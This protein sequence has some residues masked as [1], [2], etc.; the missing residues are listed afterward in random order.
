MKRPPPEVKQT[1]LGSAGVPPAG[2]IVCDEQYQKLAGGD[3]SAPRTLRRRRCLRQQPGNDDQ[4]RHDH[5]R[6]DAPENHA[7]LAGDFMLAPRR[8]PQLLLGAER[9]RG[10]VR[11][12]QLPGDQAES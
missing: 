2:F 3:A 1:S 9:G 5:Q 8:F 11:R 12:Q 6:E 10:F 4:Q 7:A